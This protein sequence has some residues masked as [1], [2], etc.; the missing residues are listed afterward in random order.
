MGGIGIEEAA[1]VG[2]DVLDGF[3]RGDRADG[4]TLLAALNRMGYYLDIEGLRRTLRNQEQRQ[5]EAD[6]QQHARREADE[7]A[8]EIAEIGAAVLTMKARMKAI[9]TTNPV[10]AEVNIGKV[11]AAIWLKFDS[12]VSPAY[13]C[14]SVFV[15]KLI[16]VLKASIGSIAGKFF[17]LSGRRSCKTRIR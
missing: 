8:I 10:A 1:T 2:A 7:I 6:R 16:A 17:G 15:M 13:P 14:Q 9:A 11:I 4:D 12:V 3:E 5:H